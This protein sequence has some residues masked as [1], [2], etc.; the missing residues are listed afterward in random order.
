[1]DNCSPAAWDESSVGSSF[2]SLFLGGILWVFFRAHK[3]WT[4]ML[5]LESQEANEHQRGWSESGE[6][7]DRTCSER[8]KD[9]CQSLIASSKEPVWVYL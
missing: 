4:P 7:G 2:L 3:L 8:H 9:S 5:S 1:V 6:R